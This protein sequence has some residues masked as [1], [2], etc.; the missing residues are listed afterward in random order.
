M[1]KNNN[2]INN[3]FFKL[4]LILNAKLTGLYDIPA[5][6]P[7]N[8]SIDNIK[9]IPFNYAMSC[10][11]P[12]QYFVHFYL[13]DYQFERIWQKPDTYLN[14]LKRFKGII[15]PD[16]SLY[17]DMPKVMQ[18]WHCYKNRALTHYYQSNALTVIP[19]ISWSDEASYSFCFDGLP[20]NSIVAVSSVGCMKNPKSL[21]NFCKGFEE[22]IKR[23]QPTKILLFGQLP[24]SLKK[25]TNIKTIQTFYNKFEKLHNGGI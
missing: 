2:I 17:I 19:N 6:N 12:E 13:D 22:M 1:K 15:S 25:Y 16:F 23:L 8:I 4:N 11:N 9:I 5:N 3:D 24:D 7:T 18:I 20:K 14:I 21:L 10:N